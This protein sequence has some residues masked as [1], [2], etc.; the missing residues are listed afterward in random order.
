MQQ[1][2]NQNSWTEEL[3]V[4]NCNAT[5][6]EHKCLVGFPPHTSVLIFKDL[7]PTN[8]KNPVKN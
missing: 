4:I 8:G 5:V 6:H 2:G 1:H 7:E 3:K